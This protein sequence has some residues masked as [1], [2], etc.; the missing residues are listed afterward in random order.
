MEAAQTTNDDYELV[1]FLEFSYLTVDQLGNMLITVQSTYNHLIDALIYEKFNYV[2][3]N[4][5]VTYPVPLCIRRVETKNSIEIVIAFAQQALPSISTLGESIKVILPEW[6]A[7]LVVLGCVVGGCLKGWDKILDIIKKHKELKK[8]GLET[9]K[10]G[11]EKE[12]IGLEVEKL[13]RETSLTELL[14]SDL[15]QLRSVLMSQNISKVI[16]DGEL[17][18]ERPQR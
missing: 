2:A 16:V 11:L 13:K 4:N 6:S 5:I 18:R 10:I 12:M 15:H 8:I 7:V 17:I 1:I 3:N 14:K 9:E